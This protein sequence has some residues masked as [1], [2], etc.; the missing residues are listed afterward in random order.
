MKAPASSETAKDKIVMARHVFIGSSLV[1]LDASGC[2]TDGRSAARRHGRGNH[3]CRP[4][5]VEA[6][7]RLWAK[8]AGKASVHFRQLGGSAAATCYAQILCGTL[9]RARFSLFVPM[10]W[11]AGISKLDAAS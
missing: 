5:W 7:P 10:V 8:L 11:L 2:L 4:A 9:L 1:D 6:L 3:L